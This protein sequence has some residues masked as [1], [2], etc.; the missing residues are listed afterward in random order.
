MATAPPWRPHTC[1]ASRGTADRGVTEDIRELTPLLPMI[2]EFYAGAARRESVREVMGDYYR[3]YREE[4]AV[5]VRQGVERDEFRPVDVGD[6]ASA[7]IAIYEGLIL[8]WTAG[9]GNVEWGR[10]NRTALRLLIAGLAVEET[11]SPSAPGGLP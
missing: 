11:S 10:T 3:T 2:Y 1:V 6:V 9:P 7:I 4:L 5:L 8:L